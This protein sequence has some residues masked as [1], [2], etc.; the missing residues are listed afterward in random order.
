MTTKTLPRWRGRRSKGGHTD[1]KQAV[2]GEQRTAVDVLPFLPP[3]LVGVLASLHGTPRLL[4][5]ATIQLLP[6][7]SR[8][9]LEEMKPPLATTGPMIDAEGH[10]SLQLTDFAYEVMAEAAAAAEANPQA[11]NAWAERA[12]AVARL[13]TSRREP[14]SKD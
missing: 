4:A 12:H 5:E 7:G 11:V 2:A 9:A 1:E 13:V 8:A 10:R 3:D 14:G 6:F